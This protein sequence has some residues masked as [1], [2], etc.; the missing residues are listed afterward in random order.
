[1]KTL[2]F[3]LIIV[4]GGI[5]GLW[6]LNRATQEGYSALLLEKNSLGGGQTVR[7]QGIIHG[8][9]KYAL[10]GVLTQA[11]NTI[12]EM[13]QRWRDCLAGNGEIDLS[14]AKILSEAH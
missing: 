5:A 11:S 9:T 1:M 2:K 14:A 12:K 3:D 13:P 6:L 4:G 7:S 8:G 10:N